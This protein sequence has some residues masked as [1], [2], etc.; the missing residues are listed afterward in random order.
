MPALCT[1]KTTD[2]IGTLRQTLKLRDEVQHG[3]ECAFLG[4]QRQTDP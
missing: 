1:C 4:Q 2:L 3:L